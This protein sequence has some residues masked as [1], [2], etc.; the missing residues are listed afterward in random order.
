MEDY[1]AGRQDFGEAEAAAWANEQREPG[2][3]GEFFFSVTQFCF[4]A[5]RL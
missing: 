1:V 4:T 2:E 3:R 5:R